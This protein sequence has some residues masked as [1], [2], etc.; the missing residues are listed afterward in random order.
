LLAEGIL[1]AILQGG[2]DKIRE[3]GAVIVGGHTIDDPEPKYGLS[4][5]GIVHP[6]KVLR[7]AG[8]KCGDA[9][10]LTKPLGTGILATASRADMFNGGWQA[11]IGSMT[12]LNRTAAETLERFMVNACTDVT[13][14]GLLGH[15]HEMAAGSGMRVL[16]EHSAVPLLPDAAEA[17]GMGLVPGGAYANRAYFSAKGVRIG[18][19]VPESIADV[20]WDPQTSGGLLISLPGSQ[21]NELLAALRQAGLT[22]ACIGQ[23][24]DLGKGEID[25]E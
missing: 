19:G 1:P 2:Q 15:L 23:V 13:G 14:F 8:A 22:A 9:L 16:L 10:I 3:A 6:D 5:T 11:A 25:V 7:N 20:L 24:I 12:A 21:A 4:V 17:A 18:P